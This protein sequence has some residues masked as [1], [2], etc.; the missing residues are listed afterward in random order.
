MLYFKMIAAKCF[1][2]LFTLPT[3]VVFGRLLEADEDATFNKQ[4]ELGGAPFTFDEPTYF[5]SGCPEG[6]IEVIIPDF[7]EERTTVTVLF[8]N[9]TAQTNG[10][11]VRDRKSC[12]M[13]LPV[14]VA[15]GLSVG[16]FK[17]DYRGYAYVPTL[18]GSSGEFNAE[19]FFA[20]LRGPRKSRTFGMG[21]A[22]LFF[23]SDAVGAVAWSECGGTTNFR[24]NTSL[25]ASKRS[26][27]DE[28]VS[29]VLD[30]KDVSQDGFYFGFQSRR[31]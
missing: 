14:Q 12:N 7:G 20:G 25:L 29:L 4:Q 21:T 10:S 9:Y 8:E 17:V 13:A 31:C 28:D 23:E 19:Y 26:A 2:L 15:P 11:V 3:A 22:G 27:G 18:H 1:L 24:I 5:G 30:S 16:I 6:S